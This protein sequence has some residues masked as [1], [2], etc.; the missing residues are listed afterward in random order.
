M[1]SEMPFLTKVQKLF[2]LLAESNEIP[3]VIALDSRPSYF[4]TSIQAF[5]MGGVLGPIGFL[6]NS[7]PYFC[8]LYKS[9]H[10]LFI[11]FCFSKAFAIW[12]AF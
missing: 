12:D 7:S 4:S 6:L 2:L 10:K 5:F 9:L 3:D 8:I 11:S 1:T